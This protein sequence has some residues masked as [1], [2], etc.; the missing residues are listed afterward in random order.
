MTGYDP[1]PALCQ[2]IR[3]LA[4]IWADLGLDYHP[5]YAR[6]IKEADRAERWVDD[7]ESVEVG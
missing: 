5:A 4:Q 2:R 6:A 7:P 3:E 1:I